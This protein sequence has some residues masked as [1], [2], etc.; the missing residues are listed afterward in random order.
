MERYYKMAKKYYPNMWNREMVDNLYKL[1]R[2]T[3]EEYKDIIAEE[4]EMEE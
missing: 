1:G 3:E 2:L 4:R